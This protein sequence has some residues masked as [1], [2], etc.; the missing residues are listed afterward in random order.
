MTTSAKGPISIICF[1]KSEATA[2]THEILAPTF[3][4]LVQTRFSYG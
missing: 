1:T 4:R 3:R 2:G